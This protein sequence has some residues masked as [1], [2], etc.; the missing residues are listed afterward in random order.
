MSIDWI[1]VSAQIIN[2]L[3]LVWLLRRFLYQPVIQAMD[4]R[5]QRIAEQLN[6]AQAREQ[7]ADEEVQHYHEKMKELD[8]T[9]DKI[10]ANAQEKAE[11]Q[12]KQLLDEARKEVAE[13]REHWQ[14][15]AQQEKEEF[16]GEL[17]HQISNAIQGIARKALRDLADADLEEQIIHSFIHR[18]KSLDKKSRELML[19]SLEESSEPIRITSTFELDS[20]VG[21]RLTRAIHEHIIDGVDIEYHESPELLCGI[22]LTVG[23]GQLGWN[24]ADY[25]QQLNERVEDTF[26]PIASLGKAKEQT[27]VT[28]IA[29]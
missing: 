11:Q 29:E 14:R 18:L 3:I 16:W 22:T 21:G 5:E 1:T 6:E 9:R 10:L 27:L 23:E 4:E 12:K 15:Q 7:K 25:L 2:F 26:A 28:A 8:R 19:N 17:R 20:T 13:T 24:L